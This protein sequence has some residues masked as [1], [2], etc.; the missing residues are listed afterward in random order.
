MVNLKAIFTLSLIVFALINQ[1]QGQCNNGC[2]TCPTGPSV[3]TSCNGGFGH[4][5][6]TNTC[7]QCSGFAF[8]GG[9]I[10][11]CQSCNTTANSNCNTCNIV[12]GVCS[13]CF[14]G[15]G[16]NNISNTCSICTGFTFSGGNTAVC[17]SCNTT[18]NTNCNTCS[19]VSG[20]C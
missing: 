6:I 13:G 10:A 2:A 17:Q 20:I 15:A 7:T 19:V 18:A 12:S 1:V 9:N 8:S 14:A 5:N 3:C 16:F 11:V 4:N